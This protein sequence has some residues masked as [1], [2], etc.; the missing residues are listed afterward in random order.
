MLRSGSR[1]KAAGSLDHLPF[2]IVHTGFRGPFPAYSGRDLHKAN[3]AV[4]AVF[5][6]TKI[7]FLVN[8]APDQRRVKPVDIRLPGNHAVIAMDPILVEKIGTEKEC[9]NCE[10]TD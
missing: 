2:Q 8:D 4:F 3:L 5:P 10:A 1:S 9:D 6:G 7:S